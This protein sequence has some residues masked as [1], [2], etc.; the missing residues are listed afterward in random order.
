MGKLQQIPEPLNLADEIRQRIQLCEAS[1]PNLNAETAEQVLLNL[2]QCVSLCSKLE[3]DGADMRPERERMGNIERRI[4]QK[5]KAFVALMGGE[6]KYAEERTKNH[7]TLDAQT[8]SWWLL[9]S[10]VAKQRKKFLSQLGVV[11]GILTI[12][13]VLA[14]AFKDIL[15][16]YDPISNAIATA[17]REIR[18]Q[19]N[20]NA[21][22]AIQAGLTVSPTHPGL[23]LW[24][25]VLND[26]KGDRAKA[27]D[28]YVMAQ[29]QMDSQIFFYE[30][31][32][33]FFRTG[34]YERSLDDSSQVVAIA[35][36]KAEGYF[37]RATAYEALKMRKEAL[38]DLAKCE[39]LA[40]EQNN[41]VLI[42]TT[43]V[44]MGML[45]QS[46]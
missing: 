31:A 14:F 26:L 11:A 10:V 27:K 40:R 17:E 12:L 22:L 5:A 21:I 30:R 23:Q 32:I 45:L 1:L 15:F 44:R 4:S 37:V 46:P 39:A 29:N 13:V 7:I 3:K 16:P 20:D 41:D 43:R 24:Y 34:Q 9:D 33:I 19:N 18:D 38:A 25:G 28:A 36:N 42:A 2:D 8:P 6:Q 35:P